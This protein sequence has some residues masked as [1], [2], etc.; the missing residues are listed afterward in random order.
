[1]SGEVSCP[2]GDRG[3]GE[4]IATLHR[5]QQHAVVQREAPMLPK[6]PKRLLHLLRARPWC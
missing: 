2:V 6:I 4:G 5:T 1:M 3:M